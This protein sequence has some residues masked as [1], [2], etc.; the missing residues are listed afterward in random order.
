MIDSV[1]KQ[2]AGA[3]QAGW[4]AGI[5]CAFMSWAAAGQ[6]CSLEV[7]I[8][9]PAE[10]PAPGEVVNLTAAG[11][12]GEGPYE[13]A[14]DLD[15][16]GIVDGR[17]E[18]ITAAFPGGRAYE[19]ALSI[20]DA[21]G[22][23]GE[24]VTRM[25]ASAP[26]IS[27]VET[28]MPLEVCGDGDGVIEPGE[29]GSVAL[30]LAHSGAGAAVDAHLILRTSQPEAETKRSGGPDAFGY[31]FADSEDASCPFD[32]VD[33]SGPGAEVAFLNSFG[34][35]TTDDGAASI[36]LAGDGMPVY[37]E[38]VFDVAMS[39]NG[40]ISMD[41]EDGG[42][43][44]FTSCPLPAAPRIGPDASRLY[45]YHDDLL[46]LDNSGGSGYYQYF[47]LC[48]RASSDADEAC[49][50]FQWDRVSF[51]TGGPTGPGP[52][53][54]GDFSFQAIVYEQSGNVVYQYTGDD[55]IEG[56]DAAVGLQNRTADA[57][58]QYSCQT[59][60]VKRD[61]AVCIAA[62]AADT[63]GPLVSEGVQLLSPA[64]SLGNLESGAD[65][66]V[67]L[68]FAVDPDVA[69]GAQLGFDALGIT[70]EGGFVDLGA[71][72]QVVLTAG[73]APGIC[74]NT[75]V[76]TTPPQL[77]PAG[78]L[79]FESAR[80][81]NGLDAQVVGDNLAMLW[82]TATPE[83]Y[84]VWYFVAGNYA[85]SQVSA[86]IRR[87]SF[88]GEFGPGDPSSVAVGSAVVT[89]THTN[90]MVFWWDLGGHRWA[91]QWDL[92]RTS[93]D[94]TDTTVTGQWY[95]PAESGWGLAFNKQ[96]NVEIQS[97]YLYD[98]AG[99]PIW[100]LSDVTDEQGQ[101]ELRGFADVHCPACP[102]IPAQPRAAG[103]LLR[104]FE[105]ARNLRLDVDIVLPEPMVGTWHRQNQAMQKIN[106]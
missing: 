45:V 18:S 9:R 68:E 91:E 38:R 94:P 97:A 63:P 85:N 74:D 95:T 78:G 12:G 32:F 36:T 41:P 16:D 8:D 84:P 70:Y 10:P 104:T 27:I 19:V 60:R 99:W 54:D 67:A 14:W 25:A 82:Y 44:F 65:V 49:H 73:G 3:R 61:S 69:C 106:Q 101:S 90:R 47:D 76:C 42:D 39:T 71:A 24:T 64:P 100:L 30:T 89:W 96:G 46:L 37:G 66:K 21:S 79:Y 40:Y 6:D 20:T 17:Q 77:D 59:P 2:G 23:A 43:D 80:P 51:G 52:R 103:P 28:A 102:W 53:P 72:Q 11:T 86:P 4:L 13:Y 83:H 105:D 7:D 34:S 5:C 35:P 15:S 50:V 1:Q 33:I 87:F 31:T 22:C 81:G 93:E 26:E 92:L 56:R 62:P 29:T 57:G 88:A 55:P 48:P 58:L 98:A 75:Q